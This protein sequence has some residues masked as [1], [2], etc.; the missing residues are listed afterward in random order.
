M[1]LNI[2]SRSARM[3]C[4]LSESCWSSSCKLAANFKATRSI[5]A[6]CTNIGKLHGFCA[7]HSHAHGMQKTYTPAHSDAKHQAQV[8]P[9][10]MP[11]R[12]RN[13]CKCQCGKLRS[14][15]SLRL[16]CQQWSLHH[17]NQ[18]RSDLFPTVDKGCACVLCSI[19]QQQAAASWFA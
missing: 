12:L 7:T 9:M 1:Y 8:Q 11:T 14:Y 10:L 13:N 16:W 17:W 19:K 2:V 18:W 15:S 5:A 6:V 3:C 4:W